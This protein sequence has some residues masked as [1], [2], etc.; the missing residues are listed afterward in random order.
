MV[1]VFVHE[2]RPLL[3]LERTKERMRMAGAAS[4]A[5]GGKAIDGLNELGAFM[6]KLALRGVRQKEFRRG[7]RVAAYRLIV[8]EDQGL[9]KKADDVGRKGRTLGMDGAH[10]HL[11]TAGA[12]REHQGKGHF[13]PLPLALGSKAQDAMLDFLHQCGIKEIFHGSQSFLF[14]LLIADQFTPPSSEKR[15]P[16]RFLFDL[17]LA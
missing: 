2:N 15:F 11:Q 5:G 17:K 4:C 7:G 1:K 16:Q 12:M 3:G 13:A 8:A 14:S 6:L 10:G 9:D